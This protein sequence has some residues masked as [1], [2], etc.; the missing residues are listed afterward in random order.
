MNQKVVVI[1]LTSFL[2]L[3]SADCYTFNPFDIFTLIK[4]EDS[5]S[6]GR[7][8]TS[9]L[10]DGQE[11]NDADPFW[12]VQSM[13]LISNIIAALLELGDKAQ[14]NLM[15]VKSLVTSTYELAKV[16]D[17]LEKQGKM[18]HF[19]ELEMFL[20]HDE[21]LRSSI[22]AVSC[23]YLNCIAGK[24]VEHC[25]RN[26]NFDLDKFIR[27]EP[28]TIYIVLP[29]HK[30]GAYNRILRLYLGALLALLVR[31]KTQPRHKTLF[32][33]DEAGALGYMKPFQAMMSYGRSFGIQLHLVFQ[34]V[35]Q[36]IAAYPDDWKNILDN[37]SVEE[38]MG[39]RSQEYAKTVCQRTGFK[40]KKRLMSLA[41]EEMLVNYKGQAQI[42]R[43]INYLTDSLFDGL[44][45]PNPFYENQ[46][47]R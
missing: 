44:Y 6:I 16:M 22:Q 23:A 33:V 2:N 17:I 41:K 25:L 29:V 32:L 9:F 14:Q 12:D 20:Q 39:F 27:G 18:T 35:A 19:A 11:L 47:E 45:D 43:K 36:I 13:T 37:A 28:M 4:D 46:T 8:L 1:D 21:K 5:H 34:S 10:M 30:L 24:A 42:V 7:E 38:Y 15:R 31:R 26:T 40:G 3:P